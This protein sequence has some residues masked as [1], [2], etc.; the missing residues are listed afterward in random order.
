MLYPVSTNYCVIQ[1]PVC[2]ECVE[3]VVKLSLHHRTYSSGEGYLQP[4]SHTSGGGSD[5]KQK[6]TKQQGNWRSMSWNLS[7]ND[8]WHV[9]PGESFRN[10]EFNK[11]E[12]FNHS[13]TGAGHGTSTQAQYIL[14]VFL[15]LF[16]RIWIISSSSCLTKSSL[17]LSR[18]N[19]F[20][21][22]GE[23]NAVPTSA[24]TARSARVSA[25][26]YCSAPWHMSDFPDDP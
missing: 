14:T 23:K 3:H 18:D 2:R 6:F 13:T 22:P 12:L 7:D 26:L 9:I 4:L 19:L 5:H 21:N 25:S 17:F 11:E 10:D 24:L 16:V 20:H 8:T 15:G 1:L